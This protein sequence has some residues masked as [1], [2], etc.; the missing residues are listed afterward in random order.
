MTRHHRRAADLPRATSSALRAISSTLCPAR[1][2][3]LP[4]TPT[5]PCTALALALALTLALTLA[6]PLT[7]P[8]APPPLSAQEPEQDH[9]FEG[10]VRDAGTGDPL[11]GA[12][13]SV[14][15]R[16]AIAVTGGDGTFH[17]TG[18]TAGV[19]TLRADRVGYRG[20]T[21]VVVVGTERARRAVA[22]AAEVVIHMS[23]SPIALEDLVVTGTISE[24]AAAEA[25]RPV[26]VMAGDVLQRQMTATVA[27]TLES[28]PGLAATKMGPSVAQPVIR[29]LSGDRVLMLVDGTPV[30]DASNSGA[31]HTTALDPSGARRIEVVRG[32]GA[33]LYGGNALGGVVNVIR[34][35]IPSAVPHS[36]TGAVTLQTETATRSLAR[37]A[38]GTLAIAERV[39]LRVE[40]AARTAGDLRTPAGRLLNTDGALWS[41]GAG[42]AYVADWGRLGTS[43][44]GYRNDY[45]IP[46]GFV[47]GHEEGVRIEMERL[48]SKF[49]TVVEQPVG[50]FRSLRFDAIHNWYTHREIEASDIVGTIFEQESVSADILGRHGRWG[51]FTAGA[52]GGRASWEDFGYGGSLYTPDTRRL[53]AALYVLEEVD[54]GPMQIESGVRYDWTLTDPGENRDSDIGQIRDRNFSSLSGSLG[55]LYKAGS[56]LVLGASVVRAFR[57]PDVTELYSEG[58]HLAAYVFEVGNP[59][60]EGEVGTGLDVF[61]RFESERLRA[62]VTGFH[63]DIRNH[64]Y[65]EDTG[66]LS[67]VLLPIYQF[68]GNDAVFSGFEASVDIDSGRGLALEG[69]ASSV[70]ASLKGSDQPLP[71]VPPLKG[72][73]AI[74][75]E[76]PWWYV[77]AEAEMAARQDRVGEFEEPTPGYTVFNA[78]AGVRLAL[79]GRLNILTASLV[80]AANTEYR[81]HLSRVKEIM[82]EAG[83][84]LNIV[85]R[86]IF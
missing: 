77:R 62:E 51:P 59:S 41:V 13:V 24:R 47:G 40:V 82:P 64:I 36:L 7:T 81:N 63:N 35:E 54:L 15:G 21:V 26:S 31:D 43:F 34:D 55:A 17:L 38:T 42:T 61:L 70:T 65:G 83:R 44:R 53:K 52:M 71:L 69:V 19:Y 23:P 9:V 58:P 6:A 75:Y 5:L 45:G 3:P 48:S 12:L 60:L 25:L 27:G 39:P 8:L 73:A 18:L 14:I 68:R 85:Y 76:R 37:S 50:P 10:N 1:L 74:K 72:H 29:G 57:T 32:P 66:K 16:E 67:R 30:G 84:G 46:G 79:G 2:L 56:G 22:E 28:M 4:P 78:T 11:A 80:N 49:R 86:V 20:A 33:L